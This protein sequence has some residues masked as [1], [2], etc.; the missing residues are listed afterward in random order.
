MK[1]G[2][3]LAMAAMMGSIYDYPGSTEKSSLRPQDIDVTP[4]EPVIQK[5]MKRFVIE[6]VEVYAI[7]EKNA[8]KKYNK[9][10]K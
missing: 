7:N 1:A 10:Y 2:S 8:I 4:K 5:G 3:L 9:Q 6:G